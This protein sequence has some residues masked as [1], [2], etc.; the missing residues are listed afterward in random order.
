[1][2]YKKVYVYATIMMKMLVV[3]CWNFSWQVFKAE[4]SPES[5]NRAALRQ[6]RWA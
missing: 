4:P 5:F 3:L 2:E 6:C 1:M